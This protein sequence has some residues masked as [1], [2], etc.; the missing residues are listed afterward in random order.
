VIVVAGGEACIV[1]PESRTLRARLAGDIA[2]VFSVPALEL[3]LLQGFVSFHAVK[4]DN[5]EWHSNRISWDGF[6][7]I[8][9][10]GDELLG[11]AFSPVSD[12]WA[13]FRLDLLTG[14][15]ANGIYE[16]EM[17]AAVRIAPAQDAEAG[18]S[19]WRI[20]LPKQPST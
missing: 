7:K 1:D 15:C 10:S 5:T 19:I 14:H 2:N 12:T 6:R 3:I 17:S 20:P 13:P 16:E 9:I 4:A 18:T 8:E 11:E